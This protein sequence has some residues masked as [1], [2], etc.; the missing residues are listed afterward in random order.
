MAMSIVP[1]LTVKLP[2]LFRRMFAPRR[3]PAMVALAVIKVMIHVPVK[4][5][6]PMEPGTSPYE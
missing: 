5:F 2:A 3:K 1:R 4:M 6:R